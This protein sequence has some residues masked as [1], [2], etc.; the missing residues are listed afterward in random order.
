MTSFP[1]RGAAAQNHQGIYAHATFQ[2][3]CPIYIAYPFQNV[4]LV[5]SPHGCEI[6]CALKQTFA[7]C[8]R[9]LHG[10]LLVTNFT[11]LCKHFCKWNKRQM[12]GNNTLSIWDRRATRG[13]TEGG[14]GMQ[15]P[16]RWV[17]MGR[18]KVLKMSQ[19]LTSIRWI[20][21]R[22]SSGSNMG[23]PNL[24]LDPGAI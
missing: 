22:K 14:K 6:V 19:V 11:N 4:S 8:K 1:L 20:F 21:F 10:T 18:R 24:L 5:V 3:W 9:F 15:F 12:W 23:A 16:G 17:K 7:Q 13:V 2:L